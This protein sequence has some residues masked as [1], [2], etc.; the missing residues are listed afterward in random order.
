MSGYHQSPMYSPIFNRIATTNDDANIDYRMIHDAIVVNQSIPDIQQRQQ[1][2][3]T[4]IDNDFDRNVIHAILKKLTNLHRPFI[5]MDNHKMFNELIRTFE[6]NNNVDMMMDIENYDN[7]LKMKM[8]KLFND[9]NEGV[10]EPKEMLRK[11]LL[12]NGNCGHFRRKYPQLSMEEYQNLVEEF[13]H[14][15]D[16][17]RERVV[18]KKK[19]I[20]E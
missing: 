16:E 12:T 7:E 20:D 5:A 19:E 1:S 15:I 9:F 18:K 11:D 6:L 3:S 14:S 8:Q 17:E 10:G 4:V 2:L 13:L